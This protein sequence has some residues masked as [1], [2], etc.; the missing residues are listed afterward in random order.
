MKLFKNYNTKS[1]LKSTLFYSILALSFSGMVSCESDSDRDDGDNGYLPLANPIVMELVAKIESD[2][3]FAFDLFKTTYGLA[4]ESNV[5]VSPL[6]VNMALSMTLNGAKGATLDEMKT[7]LRATS[8]SIEDINRYNKSLRE[9]LLA[10]DKSTTLSIANSIWYHNAYTFKNEFIT[11]NRSHYDAEVKAVDFSSSNT[12]RQIN[13]WVSDKTNKKIPQIID[14][15]APDNV[16]CLI[17]AT[18]FKGIWREKFDKNRTREEDFYAEN[19]VSMGKVNMMSQTNRFL[20]S[21]D[22]YCKYLK[23]P[24]GNEAFSMIVMLPHEGKTIDDVI[25]NLDNRSWNHAMSMSSHEVNLR[26]PRFK[27]EC[28]YEMHDAILP[29]MG[30]I[31]PFTDHADF[32]GIIEGMRICI[33]KVIHKTFVEVN[34]EG[35]EAAAATIVDMVPTAMPPETINYVV[36]RPFAFAI[37]ENSTGVILFIGKIGRVN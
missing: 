26:F 24:Y 27:A 14:K 16:A 21:D 23:L 28:D 15:L 9:A 34:E 20:Y 35:T 1:L 2:N 22:D 31:V 8:Y 10:V 32:G 33:S 18:Y 3:T 12:V 13:D 4:D 36:N 25:D 29:E 37:R 6:S 30:M 11:V 19:G 17:N 7:A 5:F